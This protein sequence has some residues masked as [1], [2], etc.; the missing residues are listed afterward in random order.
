MTESQLDPQLRSVG[1]LFG[2]D[3]ATYTVPVYQ[4]NYAW[5][6]EQIEQLIGDIYDALSEGDDGYFLGNLIVTKRP[7]KVT[8]Y[9]VI[10]G[11]QRLTTL[12][13]LLTI[14]ANDGDSPNSP[15]RDRLRYESRPRATE[16]LRR[17]TTEASPHV[18]SIAENA[19][20]E[21]TGIHEGYNV[22]RQ[23]LNQHPHLRDV[24]AR[25]EFADYLRRKVTLVRAALPPETDL[26][27]YFEIMNTR[28]QQLQQVDIV[29]ARLM[30]H[31]PDEAERS[32]FS[33]I[34]N[35]CAD[36]ESYVQMS[37]TR[38]NPDGRGKLFGDNWSWLVTDSFSGLLEAHQ[39]TSQGDNRFA[40]PANTSRSLEAALAEY[41]ATGTQTPGEDPENVRFRSTIE[42]P[43]FLLHVLKVVNHDEDEQEGKLD[44]KRLIKRFDDAAAQ[45]SPEGEAEWVRDFAFALVKL[46]NLFDAFVLK[47]QYTATTGDDGDWSLQRLLKRKSKGRSTPG[48]INTFSKS[49]TEL[50]EDG[51]VDPSTRELLLL[52]SMLRVTYTS[53]RT[54]HWITKV[55]EVLAEGNPGNVQG[56]DLIEVLLSYSRGK[57]R[58]AFFADKTPEGF[59]ISRVVFTYLDYLLL[60]DQQKPEFRFSFRNSIEHFYPQ[61]PDE[62]QSGVVVSA[63]CLNLLGN[64]AL[65]SVSANSK[66]SNS[67]PKAKAE[68]FRSTIETQSPKLGRMA[69]VTREHG[70]G[71]EQV[72]RHHNAVVALLHDDLART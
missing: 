52:E 69:A 40:G 15:Q 36:M 49:G 22:I 44:D 26:N 64:L 38:G 7:G 16:A 34:W 4:R 43:A 35:A 24:E 65:V 39:K 33:W 48:Y 46:R 31:L 14:L 57:V 23:F 12:F 56:A 30:S 55:L 5:R 54:M 51:D 62:Q 42:F 70:W 9:E 71:D 18:A 58:E 72:L 50:E 27:R 61:S 66:F 60:E 20:N 53:P 41:A 25:G 17:V 29:K 47:R 1:E 37:L 3:D 28:G 63:G 13:L 10:D 32:C 11:Q 21:D 68:N 2:R 45:A 59:N 67:L 6:A 8:D 19:T